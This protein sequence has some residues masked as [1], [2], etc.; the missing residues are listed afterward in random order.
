[1][2]IIT[3]GL[4]PY[5]TDI[6]CH[7]GIKGQ[8]WGVRRYQNYDGTRIKHRT[9][10]QKATNIA[11]DIRKNVIKYEKG[12]P[13]GNQNCQLCTWSTEMQFRGENVLPRPVYSPR[14]PALEVSGLDLFKNPKKLAIKNKNDVMNIVND[15][16]GDARF[17]MH[18]NWKDHSGGHEFMVIN[19]N[20]KPKLVDSQQGLVTDVTSDKAKS[21]FDINYS[22]SFI[23]RIDNLEVNRETLKLNDMSNVIK[24][25]N[26]KDIPYM[27]ERDMLSAEDVEYAKKQGMLKEH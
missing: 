2:Y 22:N 5:E 7:H 10:E 20:G 19:N 25:D 8:K 21:Y 24:W 6:L 15:A 3:T 18:V 17:Y 9:P 23:S 14:D 11:N 4:S 1:M 26:S 16:P 12:G 27:I 13:A